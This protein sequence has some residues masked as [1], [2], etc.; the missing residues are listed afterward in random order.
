MNGDG[1]SAT[2]KKENAAIALPLA[3]GI[4]LVAVALIGLLVAKCIMAKSA[5]GAAYTVSQPG[6]IIEV[7]ESTKVLR[8]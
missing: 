1:C 6:Q 3:L 8:N 4:P 2:C 7:E 5:A